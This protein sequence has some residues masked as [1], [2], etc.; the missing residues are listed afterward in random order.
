LILP[1]ARSPTNPVVLAILERV[2][3]TDAEVTADPTAEAGLNAQQRAAVVHT[4]RNLLIVAGAG[5]G[6]TTTLAAR[7]AHLIERGVAPERILL[8][9]FSRRAAAEM[10]ARTEQRCGHDA[11]RRVWSGTFHSIAARLLRRHGSVLGLE[12]GFTVLDQADTADLLHLVRAELHAHD[13]VTSSEGRRAKKATMASV[14]SRVVNTGTPL[15]T[16]LRTHF[17]WCADEQSELGAVFAAYTA[18]KRA[19]MVLDYDDLLR[20]WLALLRSPAGRVVRAQFDHVLVDEYQDTNALQADLLDE[21]VR[22]EPEASGGA[23]ITAVGDDAQAIFGFRAATPRNI[24]DFPT[25]FGAEVVLLEHNHR[26]T[27]EILAMANAVVDG[28]AERHRKVLRTTRPAGARPVLVSCA[29][30]AAQS[31][32]VCARILEHHERGTALR[33]QA[34]LFRTGHHSALLELELTARHVPFRKYG[35]LRFLEAAHVKDLLCTLRLV[36]NPRD[37]LAW[38]RVLQLLDGVGPAI[39][40]RVSAAAPLTDVAAL[41]AAARADAAEL[42]ALLRDAGDCTAAVAV[43]AARAWLAPM[44]A[45]RHP[46]NAAAR[47]ADLEALAQAASGSPSLARFLTEL[48]LDPPASTGDLAGPPQLDDDWLTLSTIHS[49]KGGEWNV[50]HLI[51]LADGSLPSDLATGDAEQ[52]EE[53]RRLLYVAVTRARDELRCYVPLR[54][55]FTAGRGRFDDGHSYAQPSRFLTDAVVATMDRAGDPPLAADGAAVA[56][57]ASDAL[58]AIDAELAALFE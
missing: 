10:V 14:L 55:H 19:A 52:L 39:A 36:D 9:T 53:E 37:E 28:A 29:D 21:L 56:H 8:L 25:R 5:T 6:K 32:A 26:S 33:D 18:R 11:A 50:V 7:L 58:A 17:P 48:T 34:V 3:A 20:C 15:G 57:P 23:A 45:R 43:D 42:L 31:A 2:F 35:G 13:G 46:D 22:P 40:R 44:L 30:E 24:L 16:V 41:P 1:R 27:P 49:A 51:H 4:G 47:D 38:F 54:Y 12:P